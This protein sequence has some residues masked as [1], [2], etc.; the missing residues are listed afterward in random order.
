VDANDLLLV[1]PFE[2]RGHAHDRRGQH[3]PLHSRGQ[4]G[5][6]CGRRADVARRNPGD[7]PCLAR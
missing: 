3:L 2:H 7:R 5:G 6:G 4:R 1:S